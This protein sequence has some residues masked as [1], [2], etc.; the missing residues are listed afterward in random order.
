M[1]KSNVKQPD[2][3]ENDFLTTV[4]VGKCG[5]LQSLRGTRNT[6]RAFAT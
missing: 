3:V 1:L 6:V 4:F 5:K 2:E